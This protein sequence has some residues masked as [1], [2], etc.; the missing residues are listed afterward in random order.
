MDLRAVDGQPRGS[1]QLLVTNMALEV[2]GLLMVYEHLV[3]LKLTVTVPEHL[4]KVILIT[5]HFEAHTACYGVYKDT[6]T[7]AWVA[8]S[9]S[10][11]STLVNTP[12]S[13]H[14]QLHTAK[15]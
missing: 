9:F 4:V 2:L 15:K 1:V 12:V 3:I 5:A 13:P 8:S 7:M 6:S 14:H 10:Y 11:P